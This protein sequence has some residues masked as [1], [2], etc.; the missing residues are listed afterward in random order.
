[1]A[2]KPSFRRAD[3]HRSRSSICS[4]AAEKA[5]VKAVKPGVQLIPVGQGGLHLSGEVEKN[6]VL[7]GGES[8]VG[9]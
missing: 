6:G 9:G 1:M 4:G 3:K 7:T 5:A 8:G 2:R